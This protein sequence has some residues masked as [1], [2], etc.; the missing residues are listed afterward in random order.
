MARLS[1]ENKAARAARSA[2]TRRRTRAEAGRPVQ[3]RRAGDTPYHHG[4]LHEALLKA[5]ERVLERD[6][7]VGA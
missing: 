2:R 1:K 6:G 3:R 7:L 4:D 5:A